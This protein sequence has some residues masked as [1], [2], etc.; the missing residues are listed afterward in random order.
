MMDIPHTPAVTLTRARSIAL[1]E[2]LKYVYTG[3]VF[4]TEGG[5]TYCPECRGILIVRDWHKILKYRLTEDGHCPDCHAT[6]AGCFEKFTE[7]FGRRRIP[8]SI[9]I[10][11]N[12]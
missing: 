1:D 2:G 4:D 5:T 12:A 10:S 11:H 8:I 3:N 9:P 7:Q 6:I